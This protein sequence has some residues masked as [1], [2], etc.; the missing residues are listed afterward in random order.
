M[1]RVALF[2]WIQWL[3]YHG[4]VTLSLSIADL[5]IFSD[6][7]RLKLYTFSDRNE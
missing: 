7:I 6:L 3:C 2:S 5:Y 4:I 1:E